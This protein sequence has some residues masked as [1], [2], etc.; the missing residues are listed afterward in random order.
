M[1]FLVTGSSGHLGEGLVRRL[2]AD[3][4]DVVGLDIRASEH[5]DR[6]ACLTERELV[7]DAM[8]GITTVFHTATLHKPHVATHSRQDFVDTNITG[9]LNVLEAAVSEGVSRVIF[10]ST[11]STFGRALVPSPDDPAAWIN[12]EVVPVPKNIYGATKCAAEDLCELIHKD[13]G[14][15]CLVLRTSRFFLEADDRAEVRS[16]YWDENAKANE[17]LYRRVEL[18]DTVDAH[19]C[20]HDEAESLGFGRYIIS[21]TTPFQREDL[22]RLRKE[23]GAVVAE[24]FPDYEAVYQ[25]RGWSMFPEIERVYDNARARADLGWQP[26]YDFAAVLEK[27]RAGEPLVSPLALE[28]GTKGYHDESFGGDGPYPVVH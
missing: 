27:A 15:P 9:T 13:H 25:E 8:R 4:H 26:Q 20:A 16:R 12:E 28:V 18:A 17:Y 1:R 22:P 2:R 23:P 6:Q 19:L 10:T 7:R 21:A 3:G 24:R 14:L 5:T 11:T